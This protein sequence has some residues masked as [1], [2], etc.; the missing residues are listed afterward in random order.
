MVVTKTPWPETMTTASSVPRKE[1]SSCSS[2]RC[3]GFSPEAT[4]EAETLV[5]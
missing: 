4:R 3:S 2:S 1:A 5:P